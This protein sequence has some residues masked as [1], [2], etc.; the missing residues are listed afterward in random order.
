MKKAEGIIE[1]GGD[2]LD[3]GGESTRPGSDRVAG[4]E[5]IRRTAPVIEA[6][7]KRFDFPVSIDTSKSVVAKEAV[8]AGAEIINDV[9]G[10]A[11]DEQLADVAAK[12]KT[13]LILMHLRGGFD[14]MHAIEPVDDVL[15]EVCGGFEKSI[16]SAKKKGVR[17]EQICLDVGV[18]FSKTHKQNLELIASS[19]IFAKRFRNI[20]CSSELPRKSFIGKILGDLP[21]NKRLNGTIAANVIAALN[22]ANI[23]RVHDVKP[24]VESLKLVDEIIRSR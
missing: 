16:E 24:A 8:N 21:P 3:V 23:V 18:G 17:N 13:G 4:E 11:F 7:R 5:E 12:E 10:L 2:I 20:R 15:A 14:T 6:I 22:G 19:N 1:Q 9:S